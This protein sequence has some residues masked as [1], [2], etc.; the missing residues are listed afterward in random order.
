MLLNIRS[1]CLKCYF[2]LLINMIRIQKMAEENLPIYIKKKLHCPAHQCMAFLRRM[3]K[4]P[5]LAHGELGE[6]SE[7]QRFNI[8]GPK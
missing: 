6:D 7:N 5:S 2:P 4:L 8:S 1:P 3:Q